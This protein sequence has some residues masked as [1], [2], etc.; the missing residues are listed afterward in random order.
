MAALPDGTV[1]INEFGRSAARGK[2]GNAERR[3][4]NAA[5]RYL[6][7]LALCAA[8]GA[9]TGQRQGIHVVPDEAGA[10]EYLDDFQ[11]PRFLLDA[12]LDNMDETWWS[13]GAVFNSGPHRNRTITYRFFGDRVI[14]SASVRVEQSANG[15][16]LGGRNMVYVS[17]DGLDWTPAAGSGNQE[18]DGNG[19]QTGPLTYAADGDDGSEIWV[20]LVM[21]NN[22]GLRTN[23]SNSISR[24]E[25][26]LQ[27]GDEPDAATNPQAAARAAWAAAARAGGWQPIRL[28]CRDPAAARPPHYYEDVD[29]WLTAPGTTATLDP[30]TTL[31]I[32]V[33]RTLLN[34]SRSPLS[35]AAFVHTARSPDPLVVRVV[36]RC[37]RDSSRAAQVLWDGKE[38]AAFD[39]A[40]FFDEDT[41]FHAVVPGPHEAGV[42]ELRIRGEDSG[43]ILVRSVSVAGGGT[44]RWT[45]KPGLPEGGRLDVL[46]A[47]Y[48]PDPEPP[49]ASQAVEGRHE[50]QETGLILKF[51]QQLYRDYADFGA[52]RVVLGNSGG[53]PVRV[54]EPLLL[55]GRPIEQSYVDFETSAWDARGVVWYRVRPRLIEPGRCAQVYVRFRRRPEGD[56]AVLTIPLVNGEDLTVQVPYEPAAASIDYVTTDA[57]MRR[58]YVYVRRAAG[59][60]RLSGIGL[61]G[62]PLAGASVY[63]A[64]FPG[65]V[66]LAVAELD[67]ELR[68]GDYHVVQARLADGRTTAAQFRV[69]RFLFPRSSIHIPLDRV[70]PLHMNLAMWHEHRLQDCEKYGVGTTSGGVFDLHERVYYGLGPDEP[71]AHDNRGGGYAQGLGYHARRLAD[72]GWQQLLTGFSPHVASWM[73][74]NGTTRPLNWSVYG[75]VA[76]ISCFDPYPINYYSADHAYVRESLDLARRCGAPSRMYA[77]MEAF[78]YSKGQGVPDNARGPLPAEWR[79]NV[80]QAIGCGM[81]GLTSW[82]WTSNAG[83]FVLSEPLQA[84]VG[85]VNRI[86]G[87]IETE[88]L[89]GTPVDLVRTNSDLVATG[90]AGDEAWPKPRVWASSLLAGPDAIVVV[91]V[92]HIPASKPDPP[93][94]VPARQIELT[95]ALPA[96]LREVTTFEVTEEGLVPFSA[97]PAGGEL[98]LHLDELESGRVFLLRRRPGR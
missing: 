13:P 60:A 44:P 39:A 10:F 55:N 80:V 79:Q 33:R 17:P 57:T 64:G 29:G 86:I 75:Q 49:A 18:A 2:T 30:D 38:A 63:G 43:L 9:A 82:V 28:D 26:T 84:E 88:L 45:E 6:L 51:M 24:F 19:R 35:L 7:L 89:L 5:F 1:S 76:D 62:V 50:K 70:E 3:I 36:V 78:G 93:V 34:A 8:A 23:Q 87:N 74:M 47:Y 59:A 56:A 52:L 71:D 92:N 72:K 81:K 20:R 96:F 94:I 97:V 46:S 61:D 65:G 91:A 42:H 27:V 95:V 98:K 66:A 77:C 67:R 37:T 73:I 14:L 11:T 22:C 4:M 58:L 85:A 31:G 53:V 16:N 83:G 90:V 54:A 69:Q 68:L 41:A 15:P 40:S 21:D 48:M 25:L 12:F 32:P